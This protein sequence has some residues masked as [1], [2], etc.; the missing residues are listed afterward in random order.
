MPSMANRHER[1]LS[2]T[3]FSTVN[4]AHPYSAYPKYNFMAQ[5]QAMNM[6]SCKFQ[7]ST[8]SCLFM[9]L[10]IITY[11]RQNLFVDFAVQAFMFFLV[12]NI[13]IHSIQSGKCLIIVYR[14]PCETYSSA[15][16]D[17]KFH[18]LE[19]SNHRVALTTDT[20]VFGHSS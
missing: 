11:I 17:Q 18:A 19:Q 10:K 14:F 3:N 12:H 7:E 1:K 4:S 15:L 16:N 2:P 8:C 20:R 5:A 9:Y 13:Y 6:M